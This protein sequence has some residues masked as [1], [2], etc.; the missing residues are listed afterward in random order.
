MININQIND[1]IGKGPF[2]DN[3]ESLSRYTVPSWYK[4]AKFGIFIHWG[5]YSVPAYGNEWYPREMYL[6]DSARRDRQDVSMFDYHIQ[7]YGPQHEFGYKDF[8]PMFKAEKFDPAA[9]ASLFRRAG[10]RYVMPVAE[11][12]DGFQMYDSQLSQWNAAKMG[13]QRDIIRALKEAVQEKG[14]KFAVSSHRAENWWFYD[15]GM[16]F[17]S[18]VQDD[19]FRGLYGP[20]QPRDPEWTIHGEGP[21]EAFLTDWLLRTCELVDLYQPSIVWFDWWIMNIRFKPYLKKFAAYYYNRAA[22]WG[23]EVAIN[24]KLDAYMHGTAV[25][26]IERG[27]LNGIRPELW[28][29]DTSVARNSWS[30]S[31]NNQYKDPADLICDLIDIVSKN[32][33]LLLNIGP[34]ADGTIPQEDE[35]ILLAI[36]DWLAVN[37]EGIYDTTHW[38]I[39]GEGPTQS[40]EEMHTEGKR[41]A[42]TE[43][44]IRFTFKDGTL[45]AFVMKLPTSGTVMIRSLSTNSRHFRS[46]ISSVNTLDGNLP[47]E[48]TVSNEG[49]EIDISS[50]AE[51]P[52]PT[53]FK[54]GME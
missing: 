51:T 6:K 20:A 46:V 26:D 16:T 52:Y 9:W 8:I 41:G 50:L 7:T 33:C 40:G 53:G 39:Y 29:T 31:V 3:W 42:Y 4:K 14:M 43:E 49:L 22:E 36:G 38:K 30:H 45:Y 10:A 24:Y 12:H 25:F 15:G 23:T 5:V 54:I 2:Q 34:K 27:Q 18:D 11:H 19:S 17:H 44:D 35:S 32:G 37:G 13:P 47:L 1:V 21:D 48:W 28:Q